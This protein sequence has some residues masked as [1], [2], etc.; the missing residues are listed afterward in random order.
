MTVESYQT[1]TK[2]TANGNYQIRL[3]DADDLPRVENMWTALYQHQ[4]QNGML[5]QLPVNAFDL[6]V[7]SIKP[8]L[9]RFAWLFIIERNGELAGFLAGRVRSLP[10][11]FGGA[12]V[13]FISE[14]YVSDDHRQQGLGERLVTTAMEF[15]SERGLTR[16]E[17]Q[18]IMN[19]PAARKL[20]QRLGWTE[21]LV[22]MVW[23]PS[24]KNVE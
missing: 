7:S 9:G 14:V 11:Y 19:N 5:I 2:T 12:Q 6:W 24:A 20:Y 15:F 1:K 22:Q 21:E 17:L 23:Q 16:V 3:A 13:G 8:L 10:P 18:V 4:Q